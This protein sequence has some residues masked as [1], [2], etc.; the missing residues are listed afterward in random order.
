M[1]PQKELS[2]LSQIIPKTEPLK[3]RMEQLCMLSLSLFHNELM[4]MN[5]EEEYVDEGETAGK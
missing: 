1:T 3:G 2:P 5:K 4:N